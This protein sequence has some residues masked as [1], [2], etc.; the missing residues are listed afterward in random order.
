M[1]HTGYK[2]ESKKEI[3][4]KENKK[5]YEKFAS[6]RFKPGLSEYVRT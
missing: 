5:G 2:K 3:K 4:K 1:H 6:K